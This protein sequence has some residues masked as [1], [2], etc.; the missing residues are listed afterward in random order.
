MIQ[1]LNTI[2][3]DSSM[4]IPNAKGKKDSLGHSNFPL[5]RKSWPANHPGVRTP[6]ASRASADPPGRAA[7]RAACSRQ[8]RRRRRRRTPTK[9]RRSAVRGGRISSWTDQ[10]GTHP[11]GSKR[12]SL[13]E[14]KPVCVSPRDG[15]LRSRAVCPP[16]YIVYNPRLLLE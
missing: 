2:P 9:R 8:R 11:G 10:H 6:A 3:L 5:A 1:C 12:V 16:T 14:K 13:Q 4:L 7:S 15:P